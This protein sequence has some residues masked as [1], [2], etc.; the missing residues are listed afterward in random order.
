MYFTVIYENYGFVFL[1]LTVTKP[2]TTHY[3]LECIYTLWL[4]GAENIGAFADL[5][6]VQ[7]GVCQSCYC[8]FSQTTFE[9]SPMIGCIFFHNFHY[10]TTE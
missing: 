2:T 10:L 9:E 5:W 1:H 3:A 4:Y 7:D 6:L 8:G